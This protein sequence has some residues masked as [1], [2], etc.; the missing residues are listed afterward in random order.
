MQ[1]EIILMPQSREITDTIVAAART[2]YAKRPILPEEVCQ[3]EKS[4]DLA[5]RILQT[6]KDAGHNTT[7]LHKSLTFLLKN[8]SRQFI[9]SFIHSHQFYNSEQV[10][11]R[12]VDVKPGNFFTPELTANQLEIYNSTINR[13]MDSYKK[14]TELLTPTA[15]TEYFKIF[16]ARKHQPEKWKDTIHKKAIEVA[17]YILPVSTLAHLYHTISPLTLIRY[18]RMCQASDAPQ[19]TKLII[20][21]MIEQTIQLDKRFEKELYGTIPLEET[22]EYECF[23]ATKNEKN[24]AAKEFIKEFDSTLDGKIS[25]LTGYTATAEQILA[26]AVRAVLGLPKTQLSDNEAIELALNPSKNKYISEIQNMMT[27]SKINRALHNTT[28]TFQKKNKPHSRLAGPKTQ[29]D[30]CIKTNAC[31]TIHR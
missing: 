29:N 3:D 10:S 14:L 13:Q 16:P 12:F 23:D 15:E 7:R 6:T 19:E 8:V 27:L 11:Q 21:Q 24:P 30:A 20:D 5:E 25:R 17:R 31:N 28:Y 1:P 18:K 2:C 22:L 4:R 26:S 9:W